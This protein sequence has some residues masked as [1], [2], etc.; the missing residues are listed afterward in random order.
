M[1][2]LFVEEWGDVGTGSNGN[3]TGALQYAISNTTI[4][5]STSSARTAF[6]FDDRTRIVTLFTE[7]DCFVLFGDDTVTASSSSLFVPARTFRSFTLSAEEKRVA[8]IL[9]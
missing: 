9:R 6:D 4:A 1:T 3:L 2:I 5:L 7:Q 8:V